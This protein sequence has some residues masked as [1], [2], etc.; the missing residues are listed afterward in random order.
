MDDRR[1]SI[2]PNALYALLGSEAA[3]IIVD[4]RR[5]AVLPAPIRFWLMHF[6]ARPMPSNSGERA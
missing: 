5:D 6:I 1:H 3:P 2:S 4:V